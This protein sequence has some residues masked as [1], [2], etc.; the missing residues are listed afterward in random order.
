MYKFRV[1]YQ[2]SVSSGDVRVLKLVDRRQRVTARNE[3][4]ARRMARE[5]DPQWFRPVKV[6]AEAWVIADTDED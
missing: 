5:V 4:Q 1:A 6:V 2:A 3:D